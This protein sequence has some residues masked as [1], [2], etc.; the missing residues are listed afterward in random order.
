MQGPQR[1]RLEVRVD[2]VRLG[3][4][5]ADGGGD[6]ADD[7]RSSGD[8]GRGGT[9]LAAQLSVQQDGLIEQ[10][11]SAKQVVATGVLV[12]TGPTEVWRDT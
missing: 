8:G 6:D 10:V 9:G 3:G 2:A 11:R 5:N 7:P 4:A 1:W 12:G